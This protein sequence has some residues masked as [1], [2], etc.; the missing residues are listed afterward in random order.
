MFIDTIKHL[1]CSSCDV[2]IHISDCGY[3]DYEGQ[4]LCPHCGNAS[5]EVDQERPA[6][7]FSVAIYEVSRAY[8]GP[9]EGGWY[10]DAG[11]RINETVRTFRNTPEGHEEAQK[12]VKSLLALDFVK[13]RYNEIRYDWRVFSE[14]L[15][16]SGFPTRRP[17]YC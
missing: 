2:G 1:F 4:L 3:D 5:I 10:Y 8:G 13:N 7:W 17:V 14:E 11:S 15:P 12:Y 6:T 9:E 16:A